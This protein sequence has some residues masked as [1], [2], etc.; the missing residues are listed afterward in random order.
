MYPPAKPL[1]IIDTSFTSVCVGKNL[2][3]TACPATWY[4]VNFLSLSDITLFVFSRPTVIFLTAFSISS[5]D[6]SLCL[7][8]VAII[9]ASFNTLASSAPVNPAVSP[10]IDF[11]ST[12]EANF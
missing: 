4:A 8:L 3:T 6:I 7:F 9:A 11:K 10:A 5:F 12:S 2:L 1:G